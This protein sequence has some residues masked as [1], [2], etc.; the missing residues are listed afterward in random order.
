MRTSIPDEEGNVVTSA[1]MRSRTMRASAL[2]GALLIAAGVLAACSSPSGAS[3]APSAAAGGGATLDR[4]KAAKSVKVAF[5][6]EQPFSYDE[7]G[8]LTGATPSL[9]REV[10]KEQGVENLEGVLTE[11]SALIPTLQSGRVDI[12]SAGMFINPTRCKEIIWGNP[13]Y[14]TGEAFV[15]KKGNPKNLKSFADIAANKDVKVAVLLGSEEVEFADIAGITKDQQ[16]VVPDYATGVSSVQA[17]QADAV[18]Q[19]TISLRPL[20]ERTNDPNL[21]FVYLDEQ[22]KNKD[23]KTITSYGGTGF[24]KEDTGLRD[25][26]N[27]GLK[28]LRDSGKQ[29]EIMSAFGFTEQDLPPADLT[30]DTICAG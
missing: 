1:H 24:R 6:N 28:K 12:I 30:S 9:L 21:E 10:L 22:P 11:F 26:Y 19:L 5:A 27:A 2:T 7:G 20:F 16:V 14:Q 8:K 29:L 15:V 25:L 18:I 4:I 3:G 17:G 13:E 23:G